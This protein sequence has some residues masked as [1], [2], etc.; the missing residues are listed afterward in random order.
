MQNCT[1]LRPARCA[2]LLVA[3]C[4]AALAAAQ[5]PPSSPPQQ[6]GNDAWL[7]QTAKLYYSSAKAGLKGFDCAVRPDWQAVYTT[8][9]SGQ[10]SAPDEAKVAMLNS[11]KIALHAHMDGGS[12]LDWNPPTQP[13]STDQSS[14]LNDMH[15]AIN[16]TL[17]GFMQFWT[18]F[19][20][21]QVVP[22][23]SDGLEMTA[24]ADSGRQIHLATPQVEVTEVF[25]S[26]GI[27]RHYIVVMGGT[28]IELTPTYSPSDHGLM[29]TH[30][31][32]LIQPLN[33]P[34]KGQEMNVEIAY[35]WI[36]GFPIPTHLDMEVTGAATVH[37]ALDGCTVQR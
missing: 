21:N 4:F 9:N 20:E 27:L 37:F 22:G 34:K 16:Q 11:V 36:D 13:L 30:F 15:D 14:M 25:D 26:G 32:A 35:Q 17:Q 10:L 12:I 28:R 2:T 6:A 29:V 7:Q 19:I 23:S 3:S 24:T 31:H 8:Q 33:D 5:N 18:P 1:F